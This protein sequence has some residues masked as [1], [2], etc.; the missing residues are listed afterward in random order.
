MHCLQAA[1]VCEQTCS[2]SNRTYGSLIIHRSYSLETGREG[3]VTNIQASLL[4]VLENMC[5]ALVGENLATW[6]SEMNV[7]SGPEIGHLALVQW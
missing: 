7:T 3:K 2:E 5:C 4:S 6:F 1:V